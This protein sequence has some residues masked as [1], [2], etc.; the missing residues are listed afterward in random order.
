MKQITQFIKSVVTGVLS[1]I[2]GLSGRTYASAVGLTEQLA[3]PSQDSR[4]GPGKVFPIVFGCFLGILL[5]AKAV[6]WAWGNYLGPASAF[7][8]GLSLGSFPCIYKKARRLRFQPAYFLTASIL[9]AACAFCTL[10]ISSGTPASGSGTTVVLP[11]AMSALILF[12]SGALA[13]AFSVVPGIS[14]AAILVIGNQLPSLYGAI[15]DMTGSWS[16]PLILLIFSAG[17]LLGWRLLG[18]PVKTV[19]QRKTVFTYY[20]AGGILG[21]VIFALFYNG[22]LPA[23]ANAS[24]GTFISQCAVYTGFVILGFIMTNKDLFTK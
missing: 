15:S 14:G 19:L 4:K 8:I 18:N 16:A 10:S 22:L 12:I 3:V 17:S 11:S 1:A 9:F 7:F 20:C 2:P 5:A 6:L 24:L 23:F 21:G 13:C